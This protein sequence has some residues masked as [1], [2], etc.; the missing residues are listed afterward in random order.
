VNPKR[1][2]KSVRAAFLLFHLLALGFLSLPGPGRLSNRGVWRSRHNQEQFALYSGWLSQVGLELTPREF[3]QKAWRL[4]RAFLDLRTKAVRPFELYATTAGFHQSWR[5]FSNPQTHPAAV[6]IQ[7]DRG[8]GYETI[9]ESTSG[10]TWRSDELTHHRIRKLFGR[11]A[12]SRRQYLW[13]RFGE[14]VKMRI[15]KDFPDAHKLRLRQLRRDTPAPFS[16]HSAAA[17]RIENER[18]YDLRKSR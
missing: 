17:P 12:R 4:T 7:L 8:D 2:C 1:A 6:Q 14:W 10:G 9:F 13:V 18:V 15:A 3:E 11:A 16:G 5:M